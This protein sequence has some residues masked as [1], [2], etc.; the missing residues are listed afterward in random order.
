MANTGWQN[1]SSRMARALSPASGISSG[2]FLKTAILRNRRSVFWSGWRPYSQDGGSASGSSVI[3]AALPQTFARAHLRR[4]SARHGQGETRNER[5]KGRKH[6]EYQPVVGWPPHLAED[7]TDKR[8]RGAGFGSQERRRC[9]R[10]L[11]GPCSAS[12]HRIIAPGAPR[13][14]GNQFS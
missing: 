4:K 14:W 1:A 6:T 9:E 8:A 2:G 7:S 13:G 3:P 5:P 12:S 11:L 10:A